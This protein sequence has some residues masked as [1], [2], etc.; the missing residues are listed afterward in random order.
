VSRVSVCLWA[1]IPA[2]VVLGLFPQLLHSGALSVTAVLPSPTYPWDHCRHFCSPV[3]P[4]AAGR[5]LLGR[6]LCGSFCVA[7][8][9]VD[10][11]QSPEL[12]VCV[13]ELACTC[14]SSPGW[15]LCRGARV[16]LFRSPVPALCVAGCMCTCL[17]S[18]FFF[19][20]EF[21]GFGLDMFNCFSY[22]SLLAV[23][24]PATALLSHFSHVRLCNPIDGSPPGCPIPGILQARTLEWVAISFSNA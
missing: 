21:Y 18:L 8:T 12:T 23:A 10:I 16:D 20:D 1:V 6:C 17:L 19:L 7:E 24:I 3:P 9:C 13:K 14:F 15:S 2:S 4:C 11:P 5:N 22:C